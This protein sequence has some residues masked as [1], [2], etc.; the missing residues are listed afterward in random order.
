MNKRKLDNYEIS[1]K[2]YRELCAFCE[3][4]PE[5]KE[6]LKGVTYIRAVQYN[7]NPQPSNR[8]NSDTTA[9]HA[10]RLLKLKRNCELIE[11]TA[12]KATQKASD[13]LWKYIVKAA[14]YEVSYRYLKAYDEIA[15]ERS[16]FYEYKRYFFY[17]LDKEKD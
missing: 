13:N 1:K 6:K 14:C 10:L 9:N 16:A 12:K 11:N 2:R 15:I 3:Q 8:N 4:Y 7:D 17:L 5:W